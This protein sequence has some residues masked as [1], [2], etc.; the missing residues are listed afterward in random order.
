MFENIKV[1]V[2]DIDGTITRSDRTTSK[3]NIETIQELRNKGYLFALASGRPVEDIMNRYKEWGLEKQFDFLIGWNGC[4][5]YDDSNSQTYKY[6]YL[7]PNQIK[8]I[9]EFMNKYDCSI[10]MYDTGVYLSS[11]ESER[12]WYSAFRNKR[13]FVVTKS[14]KE[15]YQKENGGIM[16][17]T[18]PELMPKIEE[19]LKDFL[20]NKDYSGF[21]TQD[22]LLE[23]AHID[24]NKAFAL[25]KYC[26]I[27]KISLED[28]MAL[29][30]T[31]NDNQMLASCFGICMKNGS[32]DTK[33]Y[34]KIITQ[35]NCDDDGFSKFMKKYLL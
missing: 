35:E 13:E 26:E 15:F 25:K 23:F 3:T 10:H 14:N 12:A 9:I 11:K 18:T 29:G 34:A 4:Q 31:T 22:D 16:F 7:K 30:D 33:N 19:D 8:E 17:R 20:I 5:L 27:H 24:C 28:C 2:S 1:I 6:N 32:L 21:K